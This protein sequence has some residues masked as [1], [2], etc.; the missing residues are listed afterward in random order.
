MTGKTI[1]TMVVILGFVWGG[2]VMIIVTAGRKEREKTS[3]A[4]DS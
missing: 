1:V 3:G 2:L 4:L